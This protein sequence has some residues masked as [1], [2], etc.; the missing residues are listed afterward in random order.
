KWNGGHQ[1]IAFTNSFDGPPQLALLAMDESEPV[2]EIPFP[3]EGETIFVITLDPTSTNG[4]YT[5]ELIGNLDHYQAGGEGPVET[6]TEVSARELG[7][8]GEGTPVD[9]LDLE[10]PFTATDSDGDS[11]N[12][13]FTVRVEDDGPVASGAAVV[14]TADEDDLYNAQ[15]QGTSPD[16]DSE[17]A[18]LGLGLAATVRGSVGAVVAFGADGAAAGG[19]FLLAANAVATMTSYGLESKGG[20]LSYQVFGNSIL[21]YVNGGKT[22]AF[23]SIFDRPV[24]SLELDP[25]T[26]NFVYRQY[27]QLDHVDGNGENTALQG[28]SGPL[29]GIDFG[30]IIDA[31]DGDGDI[32]N[33][34]GKL[35]INVV[36][37]I[38][39]VA[40]WTDRTVT[41]DETDYNQNDDTTSRG[42]AGLFASVTNVGSDSDM[43]QSPIY[44]KDDVIDTAFVTGT[45]E[46]VTKSLTLQIDNAASGVQ[47]TSGQDI[48]LFLENGLVVGRVGGAEGKAAFA[49]TID[50]DGD[51]SIAQ[52]MSL[53][54]PNTGSADEGIDLSGKISAVFSVKDFDGDVVTKSVS[55]GNKI[56]FEDDGPVANFSGTVIV[57][58]DGTTAGS[59]L[60][61]SATGTLSFDAGAD[62]AKVTNIAYRFGSTILEM[63]EGNSDPQS[64]PA[65]TSG[66]QP[67]IVTTSTDGLT[68]T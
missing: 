64:F 35:T 47:T 12:G 41:I 40:I 48:V 9:F 20:E 13:R 49:I 32:V 63:S 51:V 61:Q 34:T 54:H 55:I 50:S 53:K 66:G 33:L 3:G 36:D 16:G 52:Y 15:S 2:I 17:L 67:V 60:T 18:L 59:F 19:G 22:A 11:V 56:V 37:D 21:A 62:G 24:F 14:K 27:D 1:L 42:M 10:I 4:S 7:F 8:E 57:T 26:G 45:D 68:V 46:N 6:V 44:A 43:L 23:D 65:L 25:Q 29:A 58:E 39:E 28:A 5:F 31:K 30:A 38:P